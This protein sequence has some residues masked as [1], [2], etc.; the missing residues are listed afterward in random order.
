M[1]LRVYRV[2]LVHSAVHWDFPLPLGCAI[3]ATFV[4]KASCFL[5]FFLI[6]FSSCLLAFFWH[7]LTLDTSIPESAEHQARTNPSPLHFGHGTSKRAHP[8]EEQEKEQLSWHPQAQQSSLLGD[9]KMRQMQGQAQPQTNQAKD[10]M[11]IQKRVCENKEIRIFLTFFS[12]HNES[13][14]G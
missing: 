1:S 14:I 12:L 11:V 10:F 9:V 8:F 7:T 4:T 6:L 5:I 2:E 3:L 13:D